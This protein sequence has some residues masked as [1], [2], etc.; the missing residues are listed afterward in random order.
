MGGLRYNSLFLLPA[1]LAH[2]IRLWLETKRYLVRIP[3]GSGDCHQG[4]AYTVLETFQR[5]GVCS[6][7]YG[8]VQYK[9]PLGHSIRVG[10]SP[11]FGPPSVAVLS[12]IKRV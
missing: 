10:H 12:C 11:D 3:V 2:S 4:S 1:P 9:E 5:H 7:V 8:T 6:A